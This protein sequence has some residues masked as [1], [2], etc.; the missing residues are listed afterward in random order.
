LLGAGKRRVA[1]VQV[2]F[3]DPLSVHGLVLIRL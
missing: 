1:R 3:H 2:R